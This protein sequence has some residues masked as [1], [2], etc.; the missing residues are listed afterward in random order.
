MSETR[1]LYL[2][3]RLRRLRRELG[4]TQQAMARDLAVSPSYVAL[5]EGN[6]RPLT[7]ELLLRLAKSYRFDLAEFAGED[8]EEYARRLG[9]VLRDPLLSDIEVSPLEVADL[10]ASFPGVSE[11]LLRLHGAYAREQQA[12]AAQRESPGAAL[13]SACCSRA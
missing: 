6:Q 5:L 1:A 2:G 8:S 13:A 3:P 7:A 4:L 9:T 11:A 10:A 12:L